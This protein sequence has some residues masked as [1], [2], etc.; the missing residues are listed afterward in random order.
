MSFVCWQRTE[1]HFDRCRS[2]AWTASSHPAVP[3]IAC[4][5]QC[6]SMTVMMRNTMMYRCTTVNIHIHAAVQMAAQVAERLTANYKSGKQ[7][8]GQSG[9]HMHDACQTACFVYVHGGKTL[10]EVDVSAYVP[11]PDSTLG[12]WLNSAGNTTWPWPGHSGRGPLSN[13][14]KPKVML[15][16][17]S[18]LLWQ[19]PRHMPLSV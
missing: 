9:L 12:H 3:L 10:K 2:C 16:Q 18:S 4:H 14:S 6:W 15:A 11:L 19:R 5:P 8:H 17:Q 7:P 1:A 13:G